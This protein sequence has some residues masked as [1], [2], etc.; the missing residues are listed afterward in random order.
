MKTFIY[1]QPK[2]DRD[3]YEAMRL[4]KNL[5]GAC[6]LANI[7]HTN[8][9]LDKY[10]VIHFISPNDESRINDAIETKKPVCISALMC[11]SDPTAKMM[12]VVDKE[13]HLTAR[14]LRV[15]NK[16]DMVF[17]PSHNAEL[18]LQNEGVKK[19][20]RILPPGVALTRFEP[21]NQNEKEIFYRYFKVSH[22]AKI[23]VAVSEYDSKEEINDF[24]AIA[25]KYPNAKFYFFGQAKKHRLLKRKIDRLLLKTPNNAFFYPIVDDDVYRSLMINADIYL[26]LKE[27]RF[28]SVTLLDAMAAKCQIVALGNKPD[29][30]LLVS[31][32]T[33][34]LASN[35]DEAASY[36]EQ[37][38]DNKISS[39]TANAY[40]IAKNFSL[41]S[42]GQ[43]LLQYYNELISLKGGE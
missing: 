31:K 33:A 3:V 36:I 8:N 2:E 16:V 34:F 25:R 15:L 20:I 7:T 26:S 19:P 39:T 14:A 24:I 9:I 17:A 43:K 11:E 12:E 35:V 42:I 5:K 27:H 21:I 30:D 10:D 18:F 23:V 29:D 1:F 37:Y 38:F 6:E 28:D 22:D 32:N 40:E 41:Y 4:R 13:E